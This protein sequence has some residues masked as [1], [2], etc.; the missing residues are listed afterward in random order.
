MQNSVL[1][2]ASMSGKLGNSKGGFS[3][4]AN[5]ISHLGSW[6]NFSNGSHV[7]P[8]IGPMCLER[9]VSTCVVITVIL[10]KL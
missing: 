3:P 8:E 1:T 2:K 9:G 4:G 10:K 6:Q 7:S 5:M